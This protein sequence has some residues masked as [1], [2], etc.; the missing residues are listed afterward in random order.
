MKL[1]RSAKG[2]D[3]TGGI[4]QSGRKFPEPVRATISAWEEGIE[5]EESVKLPRRSSNEWRGTG[6]EVMREK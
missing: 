5:R 3:K 6:R 1:M 4:N 2:E